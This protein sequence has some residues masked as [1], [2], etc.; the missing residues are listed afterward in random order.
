MRLKELAAL[1]LLPLAFSISCGKKNDEPKAEIK[2][3][4]PENPP[5]IPT[6]PPSNPDDSTNPTNPP[7]NPPVMPTFPE[8]NPPIAFDPPEAFMHPIEGIWQNADC[9]Q[10]TNG[11]VTFILSIDKLTIKKTLARFSDEKCTI[12]VNEWEKNNEFIYKI[13]DAEI[14]LTVTND[15]IGIDGFDLGKTY[16]NVFQIADKNVLY[17][18]KTYAKSPEKRSYEMDYEDKWLK[19]DNHPKFNVKPGCG[20]Q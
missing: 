1:T 12:Y 7:V 5:S 14:D 10:A 15:K 20:V 11:Y 18:G 17:F 8:I 6:S 13:K 19:L 16:Y 2:V 9:S 4:V 3:T